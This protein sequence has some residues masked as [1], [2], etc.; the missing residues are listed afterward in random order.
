[1]Q[2]SKEIVRDNSSAVKR[3]QWLQN[4][5]TQHWVTVLDVYSFEWGQSKALSETFRRLYTDAGDRIY[6]RFLSVECNAV[7]DNLEQAE[8]Q[9]APCLAPGEEACPVARSAFWKGI[10]EGRRGKS[11][12]YF[13]LYKDGSMRTSIE[14]TNTPN[15]IK[16][17]NCLCTPQTTAKDRTSNEGLC[18]FWLR[19][20]IASESEVF[21]DS[22]L[23]A[24]LDHTSANRP[25]TERESSALAET[26]GVCSGKVSI[27]AI[28]KWMGARTLE[29]SLAELF[30]FLKPESISPVSSDQKCMS[31]VGEGSD[32]E[33]SVGRENLM[34]VLR[35]DHDVSVRWKPELWHLLM[36][37]ELQCPVEKSLLF[38]TCE[39][40]ERKTMDTLDRVTDL[41]TVRAY[42]QT[43][44]VSMEDINV[45][46]HAAS[47]KIPSE[48][49]TYSKL[50]LVLLSSD[51]PMCEK[52]VSLSEGTGGGRSCAD[53]L[54]NNLALAY[55]VACL[56]RR[57]ETTSGRTLYYCGDEN[58]VAGSEGLSEGNNVVLPPLSVF[59]CKAVEG[60]ALTVFVYGLQE[61]IWFVSEGS[62]WGSDVFLPWYTKFLVNKRSETHVVLE[63]VATVD[64]VNFSENA[65][66]YAH[67]V[68]EDEEKLTKG[69]DVVT[70]IER[71]L[72]LGHEVT[73]ASLNVQNNEPPAGGQSE[74]LAPP[75]PADRRGENNTP[76]PIPTEEDDE[77]SDDYANESPVEE[78]VTERANDGTP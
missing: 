70:L 59:S 73:L 62:A 71:P 27:D 36:S 69:A 30:V 18:N 55:A 22:F 9:Q 43:R 16:C 6:L 61:A 46:C 23:R 2:Q 56:C 40:G 10:L 14:G 67:S 49:P 78:A 76:Q 28:E 31:I 3:E 17:V 35:T 54:Q 52:L 5:R 74:Q 60:S 50:A 34:N 72:G 13:V 8:E 12:S 20:F 38:Q 68:L 75:T 65:E 4:S 29:E 33:G 39:D 37:V 63:F 1:M 48:G 53:I 19:Y 66:R 26:I 47:E 58:A 11:K 42:L 45:L 32:V 57:K 21:R 7:L 15:I 64:N 44:G 41:P 77:Y 51:A 25:L 24:V